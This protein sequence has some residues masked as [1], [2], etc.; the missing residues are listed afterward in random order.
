M[1][2][3][4]LKKEIIEI[5]KLLW[6]KDL[7]SGLNGNISLRVDSDRYLLTGRGTCLGRL[8]QDGIVFLGLDG[9]AFNK[10]H[11]SS[12]KLLH[13][14]VYKNFPDT[15]AVIH[16]HLTFANGYFHM[17]ST[18]APSTFE[19]RLYLGDIKCIEQSTPTVTDI[20]PVMEALKKNNIVVLRN[21]GVLAM[22][23]NLFDCFLLIQCLEESVKTDAI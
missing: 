8:D 13:S 19:S 23:K 21:H 4:H 6:D 22:G 14:E 2:V 16:T 10:G 15:Q 20:K 5:G 17:N 18:L 3:K 11:P 1:N 9:K 12:E 7:A